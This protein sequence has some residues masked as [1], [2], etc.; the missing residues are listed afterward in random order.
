MDIT[1][2]IALVGTML[3]SAQASANGVSN[4]IENQIYVPVEQCRLVDTRQTGQ[5]ALIQN[6]PRGFLAYGSDLSAQGGSPTGCADPKA[7]HGP[8]PVAIALNITAVGEFASASG[9]IWA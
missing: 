2:K 3:V 4:P 8:Q 5:P 6:Q 1:S 7:P 9:R